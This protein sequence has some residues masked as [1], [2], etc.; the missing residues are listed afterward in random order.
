MKKKIDM[1]KVNSLSVYNFRNFYR[2]H[3][4]PI[5]TVQSSKSSGILSALPPLHSHKRLG[6][7]G[8]MPTAKQRSH[9]LL[10]SILNNAFKNACSASCWGDGNVVKQQKSSSTSVRGVRSHEADNL[11]V[12]LSQHS[13]YKPDCKAR[14]GLRNN[15]R[16]NLNDLLFTRNA[17]LL[18]IIR[19]FTHIIIQPRFHLDRF[20]AFI[21]VAQVKIDHTGLH[22]FQSSFLLI[23]F[24][25]KQVLKSLGVT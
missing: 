12:T 24:F 7:Q 19:L 20:D 23:F 8:T 15:D 13:K 10:F 2:S 5:Q 16:E 22:F 6:A 17:S 18:D 14:G 21:C 25:Q 3:L 9:H 11:T 4:W 1:L